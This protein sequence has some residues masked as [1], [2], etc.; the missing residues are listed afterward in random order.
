MWAYIEDN[1]VK[2]IYKDPKPFTLNSL[3]YPVVV[4]TLWTDSQREAISIFPVTAATKKDEAYY[5]LGNPSYSWNSGAKRV[6]ETYSP[7]ARTLSTVKT[8]QTTAMKDK[9]HG[10]IR[11]YRWLVERKIY[12]DTAIPNAV[13]TYVA[14]IRSNCATICAN[15]ANAANVDAVKSA[16]D[17]GAWASNTDAVAYKRIEL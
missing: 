2:T 7:S 6:T 11:E 16:V 14:A 4:F 12:A 5:T 3:N 17:N 10:L 15:I 9:A 8:E 13:T 1:A